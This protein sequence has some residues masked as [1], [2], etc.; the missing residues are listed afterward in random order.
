M[1][2][3]LLFCKDIYLF[4]NYQI[5]QNQRFNIVNYHRLSYVV[6]LKTF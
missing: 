1:F 5:R 6:K 2:I 4:Q 3:S